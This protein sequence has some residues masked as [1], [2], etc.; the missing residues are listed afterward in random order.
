MALLAGAH[1]GFAGAMWTTSPHIEILA[2]MLPLC[3]HPTDHMM[4]MR[5]A[6]YFGAAK[7]AILQLKTY[8]SGGKSE[9]LDH[10]F[11]FPAEYTTLDGSV[12][13]P[14]TYVKQLS[15]DKLL[16]HG[17]AAGKDICIK[18]TRR[19]SKEA[20]LACASL[21]FAPHLR[22]FH[23]LPGGWFMVVMDLLGEE[24]DLLSDIGDRALFCG[25]LRTN[26]AKLHQRRYV[27]GDIRPTNVMV[28]KSGESKTMLLD[29]DWAGVIDEARY[30]MNVNT[31][32]IQRPSGAVDH[33]LILVDHDLEMVD[34]LPSNV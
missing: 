2:P 25:E 12:S 15:S 19:Y 24:Y 5:A 33:A 23:T 30:P 6:R 26:I 4:R 31:Q 21:G 32:D 3:Y 9:Q 14:F 22:G 13:E 8:Y 28:K 10:I 11:P 34:L 29:F 7:K 20:H 18:F 17:L 1:L 27:H 16:F